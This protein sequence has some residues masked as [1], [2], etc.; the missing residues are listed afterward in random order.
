MSVKNRL[1]PG[2]NQ[3]CREPEYQFLEISE[4]SYLI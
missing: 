4:N 2:V 1:L 3:F